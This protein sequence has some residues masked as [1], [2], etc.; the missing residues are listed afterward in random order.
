MKC[1]TNGVISTLP[2]TWP[3]TALHCACH[4]CHPEVV[5]ILAEAGASLD[6]QNDDGITALH[7]ISAYS[8]VDHGEGF[9]IK[10]RQRISIIQTLVKAGARVLIENRYGQIP[11]GIVWHRHRDYLTEEDEIIWKILVEAECHQAATTISDDNESIYFSCE[12]LSVP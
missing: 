8:N 9:E 7:F 11:A 4:K 2:K 1:E 3:T 10:S 12:S 5:K 6:I